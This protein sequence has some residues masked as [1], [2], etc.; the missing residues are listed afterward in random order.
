[1]HTQPQ[2]PPL[3]KQELE[4]WRADGYF[5]RHGVFSHAEVS[6]LRKAVDTAATKADSWAQYGKTYMLD[7]KR[8]VDRH[9]CTMQ[10]EHKPGS[11][12][13]R[14]V[15][16]INLLDRR[17]DQLVDDPR[18]VVPMQSLVGSP[19]LSLWTAAGL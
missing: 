18:L 10:Y 4:Q 14:V 11:T 3:N 7:G 8:F 19:N 15:E 17:I 5:V 1:M 16:P 9:Q 2:A 13:L 12:T 6:A